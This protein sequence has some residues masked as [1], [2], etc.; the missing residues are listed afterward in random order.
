MNL[1]ADRCVVKNVTVK[2]LISMAYGVNV[3]DQISGAPGWAN[4][5][6]YDIDAKIEDSLTE[7]LQPLPLAQQVEQFKLLFRSL[8]ADRFQLRVSYGTRE[9]PVFALVVAKNGPKLTPTTLPPDDP[10][11]VR[12]RTPR[13]MR[14]PAS[15]QLVAKGQPIAVLLGILSKEVGGRI[16]LDETGLTGEYDFKLQWTPESI[17]QTITGDVSPTAS[18]ATMADSSAPSIFT[19]LQEQLGLKLESKKAPRDLIVIEHIEKP[20]EN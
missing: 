13:F 2:R 3:N 16:V 8:L 20:S 1:A 6:R 14:T 19:A 11:N 7:K 5:D 9:L 17:S 10:A 12:K 4:S 18:T 15:G